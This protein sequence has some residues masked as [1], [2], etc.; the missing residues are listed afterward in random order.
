MQEKGVNL[1]DT[2]SDHFDGARSFHCTDPAGNVIQPLYHPA[3]S[4]QAFTGP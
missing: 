1:L 2:P 4:G 3:L